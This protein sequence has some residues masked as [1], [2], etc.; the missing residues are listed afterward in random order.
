MNIQE[1]TEHKQYDSKRLEKNNEA[2]KKQARSNAKI[3]ETQQ[4]KRQK[5]GRRGTK[6]RALR[7]FRGTLKPIQPS[8][9]QALLQRNRRRNRF[10]EI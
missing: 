1:L 5:A 10:Q 7:S 2:I 9:L 4:A 8:H 3:P 6:V